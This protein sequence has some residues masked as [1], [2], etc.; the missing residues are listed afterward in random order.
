MFIE[1]VPNRGSPPAILLRESYRDQAGKSQKRTLANERNRDHGNL[2]SV[3]TAS[4]TALAAP[5]RV[6]TG[7]DFRG[8][9]LICLDIAFALVATGTFA[10]VAKLASP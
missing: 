6:V 4:P 1:T 10:F 7:I 3:P 5:G 8:H 9:G 2:L